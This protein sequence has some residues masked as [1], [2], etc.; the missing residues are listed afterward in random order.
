M[1]ENKVFRKLEVMKQ[2][3]LLRLKNENAKSGKND[4]AWIQISQ[5]IQIIVL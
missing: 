5:K 1:Q 3:N 2:N 4:Q